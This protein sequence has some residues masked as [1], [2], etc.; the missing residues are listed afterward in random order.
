MRRGS[1]EVEKADAL[2]VTNF[3]L[4][5]SN[6]TSPYLRFD[7]HRIGCLSIWTYKTI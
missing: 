7:G 4:H 6:E 1:L 3:W 5:L 2:L